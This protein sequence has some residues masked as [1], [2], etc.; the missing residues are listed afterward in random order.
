MKKGTF[1]KSAAATVAL[2]VAISAGINYMDYKSIPYTGADLANNP[3][4][5]AELKSIEEEKNIEFANT[6]LLDAINESLGYRLTTTNIKDVTELT[7]NKPL[8]NNDFSD[9]KYFTNLKELKIYMNTVD[10]ADLKYNQKLESLVLSRTRLT[11]SNLLPN[12]IKRI[13]FFDSILEDHLLYLPYNTESAYVYQMGFTNIKPK[14][15]ERLMMLTVD[16]NVA[17]LDLGFLRD[18][19]NLLKLSILTCPNITSPEVLTELDKHCEVVLDDYATIW[20]NYDIYNGIKNLSETNK[21][22]IRTETA[23]L[24]AIAQMLVP[25]KDIPDNEKIKAI[26]DYIVKTLKYNEGLAEDPTSNPEAAEILNNRPIKYALSSTDGYDEVCINYACLFQ[27]LANRVGLNSKQLMASGHTWNQVG[28]KHIDLTSLDAASF[29]IGED[30]TKYTMEDLLKM[31]YD[32]PDYA[33]FVSDDRIA[34]DPFY[35]EEYHSEEVKNVD[36]NIGYVSKEAKSLIEKILFY[37]K[38]GL[39]SAATVCAFLIVINIIEE[40]KKEKEDEEKEYTL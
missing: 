30:D 1:L 20:L 37:F 33:Y 4:Y 32:I 8:S 40:I 38:N 31:E 21:E 7:I 15:P 26:S 29:I 34:K 28:D 9:L 14:N 12:S 2:T 10:L 11:N 3:T 6:E 17:N 25:N 18:C 22:D 39:I 5:V 19:K 24:D 16:S 13:Y 27:A 36:Y 23:A 35:E